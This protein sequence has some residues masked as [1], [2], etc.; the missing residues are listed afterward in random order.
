M[1]QSTVGLMILMVAVS[2]CLAGCSTT[3]VVALKRDDTEIAS[4][5]GGIRL[6][7]ALAD[8]PAPPPSPAGGVA[9]YRY[10]NAKGREAGADMAA[11]QAAL[12]SDVPQMGRLIIYNASMT[13]VVQDIATTLDAV[14]AAAE[15]AGGYMQRLSGKT[16][17]VKVPAAK[18]HETIAAYERLGEVTAKD[19]NGS[20]ITDQMRDLKIRLKNAEQMRE[21]LVALLDRATKVEDALKIEQ[22]LGRVT[23]TIELL[24]GEI[25]ALE[26]QVSFSTITVTVNSPLPQ[27]QMKEEIPFPWV[28][29]L[30]GGIAEGTETAPRLASSRRGIRFDLPKGFAQYLRTEWLT[31]ATSADGVLVKVERH[32]NVEGADLEFWTTLTKRSLAALHTVAVGDVADTTLARGDK[33]RVVEGT[34]AIGGTE[35]SYIVA[36]AAYKDTVFSYE[37]WG[38]SDRFGSVKEA[39][40][41]SIQTLDVRR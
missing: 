25:Y 1:R 19:V 14:K 22:E 37:A 31:R 9:E 26:H 27:R 11:T 2:G 35:F 18:F 39:I 7:V 34:K 33:A 28:R 10:A 29:E 23:E 5:A 20:D 21:R 6:G 41:G 32:D 4:D 40:E 38:P 36:L 15:E 16:I 8:A 13:L 3:G 30:A 17:Q 24:K 12:V